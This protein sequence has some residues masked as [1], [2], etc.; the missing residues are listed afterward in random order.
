MLEKRGLDCGDMTLALIAVL[1][2]QTPWDV[3]K[4]VAGGAATQKLEKAVNEKN[5]RYEIRVRQ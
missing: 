1:L 3:A 4:S 2:A 5:R